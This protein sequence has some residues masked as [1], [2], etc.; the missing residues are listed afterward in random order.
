MNKN[1]LLIKNAIMGKIPF[2]KDKT[3]ALY[4]RYLSENKLSRILA[5]HSGMEEILSAYQMKPNYDIDFVLDEADV[6][7]ITDFSEDEWDALGMLLRAYKEVEGISLMHLYNC[8]YKVVDRVAYGKVVTG[9]TYTLYSSSCFG[10]NLRIYIDPDNPTNLRL[11]Y[12]SPLTPNIFTVDSVKTTVITEE[13]LGDRKEEERDI[14]KLVDLQIDLPSPTDLQFTLVE[15][16]Y[17]TLKMSSLTDYTKQKELV[18]E[19]LEF[20]GYSSKLVEFFAGTL[21]TPMS[22]EKLISN[23]NKKLSPAGGV[24][25]DKVVVNTVGVHNKDGYVDRRVRESD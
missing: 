10:L 23:L 20:G 3:Q 16:E 15:G 19:V 17:S 13:T 22:D 7:P 25:W 6:D 18:P 4:L 5:D 11:I 8:L 24:L 21:I 2:M 14:G 12:S 1:P 9:R